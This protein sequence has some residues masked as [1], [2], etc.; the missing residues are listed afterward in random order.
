MSTEDGKFPRFAYDLVIELEGM[1]KTPAFPT[2]AH[3][4]RDLDEAALRQAAFTAGARSLVDQ[5]KAWRDEVDDHGELDSVLDASGTEFPQV[6]GPDGELRR[7]APSEHVESVVA[8]PVLADGGRMRR[9][10]SRLGLVQP[11]DG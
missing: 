6:F 4:F 3:G 7:G 5:V 9:I 1:V 8:E 10:A 2:T 11:S